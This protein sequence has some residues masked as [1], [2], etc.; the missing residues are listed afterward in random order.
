MRK[1]FFAIISLVSGLSYYS[2]SHPKTIAEYKAWF[3]DQENGFIKTKEINN[4]I[5]S[6]QY[7]PVDLFLSGELDPGKTYTDK[8]LDSLREGYRGSKYFVLEIAIQDKEVRDKN[9]LLEKELFLNAFSGKAN[10]IASNVKLAID[11][12]TISPSIFHEEN[13]YELGSRKRVLFAFPS[14]KSKDVFNMNFIYNDEIFNSSIL[15][16]GFEID[17][18]KVPE[19]PITLK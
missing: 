15:N 10:T 14:Q 12:D 5:F 13:G 2:C 6:V 19:L 7:R 11:G 16:F 8:E 4:L 9:G 17:E 1:Y 18:D 3:N